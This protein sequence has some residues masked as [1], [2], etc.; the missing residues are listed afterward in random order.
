MATLRNL[1]P[2]LLRLAG[3]SQIN[4]TLE[5]MAADRTRMLP[6]MATAITP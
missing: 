5:R 3:I 6:I 1:A 4:R 2:G